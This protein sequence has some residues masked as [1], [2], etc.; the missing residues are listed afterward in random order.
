MM[1][2]PPSMMPQGGGPSPAAGGDPTQQLA[3]MELARQVAHP[4]G[5]AGHHGKGQGRKHHGRKGKKSGGR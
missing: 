4:S 3:A 5:H 2:Q 1:D